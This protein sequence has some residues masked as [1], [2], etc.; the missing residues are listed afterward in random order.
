MI[1]GI[2]FEHSLLIYGYPREHEVIWGLLVGWIMPL[3]T[4]I[5]GFLFKVKK[6]SVYAS[7][8]LYPIIVFSSI[9]FFIGYLFYDK[10]HDGIHLVGYAMWYLWAL[11]CYATFTPL[12]LKYV[13]IALLFVLSCCIA[14]IYSKIY[15][16]KAIT[17]VLTE[18][19]IGRIIGFYPFFLL[20]IMV[21]K[22]ADKSLDWRS[23]CTIMLM[24][25]MAL[26]LSLCYYVD[27]FA[28]KSGFYLLPLSGWSTI[29]QYG[30]SYMLIIAI[31]ISLLFS[32][33]NKETKLSK[34]GKRT[35]NVY[36][37]HMIVVFPL[38][39]GIFSKFDD[40]ILFKV[41]NSSLTCLLCAFFFT[42]RIDA[43]MQKFLSK[44]NWKLA[45]AIYMSSLALVN[46]SII[47]KMLNK[48]INF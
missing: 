46:S 36:L 41:I 48:W 8:Y 9:N 3:F 6:I 17:V 16:P 14:V 24:V 29:L 30:V 2:V 5:S 21:K 11:F 38:C 27:G 22:I 42:E 37:L 12:V 18:F 47:Y 34:Y 39:Y 32:M 10:Y 7:K 33:P 26:Y 40:S 25:T 45:V 23:K 28:Y 15:V 31:C 1:V 13:K 35:L 44:Q 20:G 43:L 4:L 19:Q